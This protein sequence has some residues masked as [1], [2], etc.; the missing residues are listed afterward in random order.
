MKY[1]VRFT[2]QFKK[3]LKLAKKQGKDTEKLFTMIEKLA[4][5]EPLEEKFRDHDLSGCGLAGANLIFTKTRDNC[6]FT[7]RLCV[8]IRCALVS[9]QSHRIV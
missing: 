9:R 7:A 6:I 2:A 3:D 1:E 8:N 5:G 4:S